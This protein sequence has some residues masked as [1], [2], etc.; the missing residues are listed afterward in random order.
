MSKAHKILAAMENNP[1]DWQ[2][3]QVETVAKAFGLM[4]HRP[5][6]SHHIVRHANGKK[7]SIPAHRPIKPIYIRQFVRLVKLGKGDDE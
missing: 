7:L 2:M 6:G 4:V 3:D 1:L 5:G